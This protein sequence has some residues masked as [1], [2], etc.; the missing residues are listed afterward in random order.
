MT[1]FIRLKMGPS[2]GLFWTL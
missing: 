1:D 2:S